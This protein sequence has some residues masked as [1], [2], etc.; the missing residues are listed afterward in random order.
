[1][2]PRCHFSPPGWRRR[3]SMDITPVVLAGGHGERMQPFTKEVPKAL[4]PV[5]NCPLISLPLG[6]LERCGFQTAV[7]VTVESIANQLKAFL[8]EKHTGA[9]NVDIVT[10][11][12]ESDTAEALLAAKPKVRG[13]V[14][15]LCADLVS[16]VPL[17][18]LADLHHV[19]DAAVTVLLKEKAVPREGKAPP[20][21]DAIVLDAS[22]EQLLYMAAA[23]DCDGSVDI[24][25]SLLRT[26]GH[27]RVFT[28]LVDVHC[29][30]FAKWAFELLESRPQLTN[31][32]YEL[33]PFLLRH[34]Y[35]RSEHPLP[36]ASRARP[37]A[38]ADRGGVLG[39]SALATNPALLYCACL[40]EPAAGGV[41]VRANTLASYLDVNLEVARGAITQPGAAP[42]SKGEVGGKSGFGA[43]CVRGDSVELGQQTF[44]KRS[45]IGDHCRLGSNVKVTNCVVMDHV[46]IGDKVT[47]TN[48][49][50][51][52][53]ADLREGAT[54]KDC[55]VGAA[56][57]VEE[58]AME[59][60][61]VLCKQEIMD[62][63]DA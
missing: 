44:V 45:V 21:E 14:L 46:T 35:I 57:T 61:Q 40:I 23:T 54:L 26:H 37:H 39:G 47:I 4:L 31:I 55:H 28:T 11:P 12:D 19:R 5:A 27:V 10:V 16:D 63:D 51:G 17:Q 42:R 15:V 56:F 62:E 2:R 22:K 6:H 43:E 50:I 33:L 58:G 59:K 25:A 36:E 41:C 3:S 24:R 60:N 53:N 18:R 32:R 29:Y 30:I 8:A 1:L 49:I 7:V 9:L 38:S 34:Q 20:W 52:S 48:C 13:D